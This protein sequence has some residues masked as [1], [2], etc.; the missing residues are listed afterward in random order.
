MWSTRRATL[1]DRDALSELCAASVGPDDYVEDFLEEF[2]KTGVVW[3]A[4]HDGRT[5][6]MVVYHDVP[7]GSAWLHAAR[8]LPAYRRQGVATA[9]MAQCEA[10]ARRRDRK[11]MRLWANADNEA[12][13]RAN[14]KYGFHERARFTRTRLGVARD[15]PHLTLEPLTGSGAWRLMR[16]SR[17]LAM[18]GGYLFHEFYF[19][20]VTLDTTRRLG[21][22]R[23]LW[24]FGE[25]VVSLSEDF[26]D[27]SG[28][29]IQLQ[30]VA[31]N[32][33]QILAA[34]PAIARA[35]GAVRVESFLP[36]DPALL[37]AA[38]R[39]GFA[40][41]GWGQEAVLFEKRLRRPGRGVDTHSR[42]GGARGRAAS[43]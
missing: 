34:V 1:E 22:G 25:N 16:G 14:T 18:G 24:R 3:V 36:R 10:L 41:M 30:L 23:A 40:L 20:P 21:A 8:T 11:A 17:L 27:P 33:A 28:G 29:A 37:R 9:L 12:S 42:R 31:G 39:A 6:G 32:A 15:G 5:I 2:L 7:D 35:R 13:V 26:E 38:R 43:R 19:V 4:D